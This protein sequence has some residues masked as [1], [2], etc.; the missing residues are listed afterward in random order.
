MQYISGKKFVKEKSS[1][2]NELFLINSKLTSRELDGN[3][4]SFV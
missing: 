3:R 2:K 1:S 4:R